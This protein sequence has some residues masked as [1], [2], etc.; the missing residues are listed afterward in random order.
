MNKVYKISNKISATTLILVAALGISS[1]ST[2]QPS[3]YESDGVYYN[4]KTDKTYQQA[5]PQYGNEQGE[6]EN[7]GE[8]KIGSPYFDAEGNGAEQFYY[9]DDVDSTNDNTQSKSA[10]KVKINGYGLGGYNYFGNN[11]YTLTYNGS[12]NYN[13]GRND[14]VEIN[15][16]N[17]YPWYSYGW[18][19]FYN[20]YHW[21]YYNPWYSYG[22]GGFYNPYHWG[23]YNPWYGGYY[24][25]Y[26]GWNNWYGYPGYYGY[27]YGYNRPRG[28]YSQPGYRNGGRLNN[29]INS[30]RPVGSLN[31]RN[32]QISTGLRPTR[33]NTINNTTRPTREVRP[34]QT[35]QPTYNTRPTR[36]AQQYQQPTRSYERTNSMNNSRPSYST[37]SPSRGSSM[38]SGSMGGGSRGSSTGGG[39][40]G[41]RR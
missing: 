16:W 20:P 35:Q 2:Y 4:P 31:G 1:C 26:Y 3:G 13:W 28:I 39:S 17:N 33:D 11:D 22:W 8:I 5:Q 24:G 9:Q 19:G 29:T 21:G 41:G 36:E 32:N 40:R 10:T 7:Q 25:G 38:S 14:G 15:I 23:Y 12:S 30:T 34:T 37:P 6:Q 18:G 27:G